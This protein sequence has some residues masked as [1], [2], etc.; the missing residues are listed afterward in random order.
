MTMDTD[1]ER[2]LIVT[3][4]DPPAA[5]QPEGICSPETSNAVPA[6]MKERWR[7]TTP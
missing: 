4:L 3:M 2:R 7:L 1:A 6:D 5:G